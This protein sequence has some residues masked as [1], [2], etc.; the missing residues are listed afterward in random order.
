[1]LTCFEVN[2]LSDLFCHLSVIVYAYILC[3]SDILSLYLCRN[4]PIIWRHLSNTGGLNIFKN[5]FFS[6]VTFISARFHA[7]SKTLCIC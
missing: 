3:T 7:A 2:L 6:D 4:M 5:L 1:M